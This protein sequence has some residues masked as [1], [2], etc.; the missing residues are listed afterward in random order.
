RHGDELKIRAVGPDAAQ[1]VAGLLSGI[2]EALRVEHHGAPPPSATPP[3]SA[4]PAA[5]GSMPADGVFRGTIAVGGFAVGRAAR[6]ER[7]EIAVI[8]NGSG[9]AHE[10]AELA[11]ARAQTHA[12]LAP[13]AET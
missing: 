13:L 6:I 3:A 1:S 4:T 12:R 2:D 10:G 11:R 9:T 7:R 8:E 5:A